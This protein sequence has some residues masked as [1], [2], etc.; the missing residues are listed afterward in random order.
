MKNKN[1]LI[2]TDSFYPDTTSAAQLLKDLHIK[3]IQK[4][5]SFN[6]MCKR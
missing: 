2:V 4:R 3:L 5:K 6:S 1:F